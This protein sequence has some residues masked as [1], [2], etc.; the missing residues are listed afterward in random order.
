MNMPYM[1]LDVI[2][3]FPSPRFQVYDIM[4]CNASCDLSHRPLHHLKNT[5]T[6]QKKY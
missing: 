5:K 1:Y 3:L 6:K 4:S 2:L